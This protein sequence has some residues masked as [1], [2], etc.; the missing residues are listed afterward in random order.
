M[1]KKSEYVAALYMR[2]SKEDVEKSG[3]D[4]SNSI[5]NQRMLLREY[6]GK[7]SEFCGC[8][9]IEKCD[10][11]ISGKRLDRPAFQELMQLA[12][13]GEIDC[14]LVKDFSR[15]GRDYIVNGACLEQLFPALGVRFIS[16]NDGY[17]SGAEGQETAGLETAIRNFV[18]DFYSRDTSAKLRSVRRKLA[19]E[20]AFTSPNAPY[21]YLKSPQDKHR[22][23]V[24]REAAAVVQDIFRLRLS[25][26]SAKKITELLNLQGVPSPAQY[27]LNHKRGMDWRRIN[28]KAAWDAA[29]VIAILTDE[30]YT[31]TM[32]SLRRTLAG[33][34]GRDTAVEPEQWIRVEDTHEAI[35][36][37][38]DFEQV[39]NSFPSYEKG[40]PGRI[41]RYNAF[42]CAH[43]GRRLSYTRD[44]KKLICRYGQ[45][46]PLASCHG[47]AYPAEE[48]RGAVL[49][50]LQ[51]QIS[52]FV[53]RETIERSSR[54]AG[55]KPEQ[56]LKALQKSMAVLENTKLRLYEA[57]REGELSKEAYKEKRKQLSEQIAA[58]EQTRQEL[59][60]KQNTRR[61]EDQLTEWMRRF[62]GEQTLTKEMERIF[63]ERVEV[64][65]ESKLS[66]QWKFADV[67]AEKK[68]AEKAG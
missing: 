40:R 36:S 49:V 23:I 48:I 50:S 37:K 28:E 5:T 67:F 68:D 22:L 44:R 30:R 6:L 45:T 54:C 41:E 26:L 38:T 56:Q 35:V 58:L 4:E 32:V 66:I 7:H 10:D 31:G 63:V 12:E 59:Y 29:K 3:G 55:Q 34:Y 61:E 43:C 18:Y 57:Y 20:G 27:A 17:D 14:I 46:N 11:G 53:E 52:R 64:Y 2:I 13:R 51:W 65:D 25:G 15:F 9:V 33:V 8:R 39:Q 60:E 24:D 42:V 47:A 1:R 19:Q 16:V 62:A 21:G